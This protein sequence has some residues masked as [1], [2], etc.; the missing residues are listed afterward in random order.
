MS[1]CLEDLTTVNVEIIFFWD[2][3]T[4]L[5]PLERAYSNVGDFPLTGG[6]KQIQF[7]KRLVSRL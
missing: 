2:V 7:P 6:R 3:N 4:R 1:P 5:G